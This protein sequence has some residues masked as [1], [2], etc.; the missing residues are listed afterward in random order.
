MKQNQHAAKCDA[1]ELAKAGVMTGEAWTVFTFLLCPTHKHS[2]L[3]TCAHCRNMHTQVC[4]FTR[5]CL[6]ESVVTSLINS[7]VWSCQMDS[8]VNGGGN[9]YGLFPVFWRRTCSGSSCLD[10]KCLSLLIYLHNPCQLITSSL[11]L[12]FFPS[13][14]V[15]FKIR[16]S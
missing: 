12:I 8:I 11:H 9:P 13:H 5:C 2:H 14:T 15:T 7:L 3:N 1:W 16:T 4:T 6:L 10:G